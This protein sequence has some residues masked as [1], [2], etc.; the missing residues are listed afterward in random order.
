[1]QIQRQDFKKDLKRRCYQ[2]SLDILKLTDGLPQKR[3]SW[4]IADQLIRS[5]TSI[6]A[7]LIEARASSLRLEFKKFYEISLKSA[8]ETIYWLGLL[9]DANLADKQSVNCLLEEANELARMLAGG[10]LKLK[11]KI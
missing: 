5:A 1:M 3:S 8:N 9:R 4:V 6:G 7:N 2:F 10:V 11:S